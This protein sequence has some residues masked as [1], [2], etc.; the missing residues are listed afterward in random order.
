MSKQVTGEVISYKDRLAEQVWAMYEDTGDMAAVAESL[1]IS[2]AEVRAILDTDPLKLNRV[3]QVISD[4]SAGRWQKQESLAARLASRLMGSVE[5]V[6]NHIE[7][8]EKEGHYGYTDASDGKE[9]EPLTGLLHPRTGLPMTAVQA[10]QWL[11]D[12]KQLDV[13]GRYAM[14]SA[15]IA[16]SMRTIAIGT[17]GTIR[18]K[19]QSASEGKSHRELALDI[20][21]LIESGEEDV[22]DAIQVWAGMVLAR[23]EGLQTEG[24]SA[25]PPSA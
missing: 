6:L 16:D 10:I 23:T 24:P 8:C 21:D 2:K 15:R 14:N 18:K 5:Q 22:P 3:R 17:E 11:V 9:P 19:A 20:Q 7:L 13:L 25:L 12:T 1:D 4:E